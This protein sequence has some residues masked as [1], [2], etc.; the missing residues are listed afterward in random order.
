M[1]EEEVTLFKLAV[2]CA[3]R[4]E[5]FQDF[6][7]FEIQEKAALCHLDAKAIWNMAKW[8]VDVYRLNIV[9]NNVRMQ[10]EKKK[11]TKTKNDYINELCA[12]KDF[13]VHDLFKLTKDD[14]IALHKKYV[15]NKQ[16]DSN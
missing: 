6:A 7:T 12:V 16:N 15:I 11:K 1:T 5:S 13:N 2:C 8:T 9:E 10:G 4:E 14:I 3:E